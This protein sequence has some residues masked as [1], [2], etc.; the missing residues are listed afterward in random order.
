M[1][2]STL[3]IALGARKT[4][5]ALDEIAAIE[6]DPDPSDR[7][8]ILIYL[9]GNTKPLELH[10]ATRAQYEEAEREISKLFCAA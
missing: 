1:H 4:I 10:F 6:A 7:G 3:S 5:V 2:R 9:R 8:I